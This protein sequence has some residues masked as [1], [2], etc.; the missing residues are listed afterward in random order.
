MKGFLKTWILEDSSENESFSQ[1][2]GKSGV[3]A[4][5]MVVCMVDII[6]KLLETTQGRAAV[7]SSQY[8]WSNAFDQQDPT[9]TIQKFIQLKIQAS[10]IPILIDFISKRSMK[11]KFNGKQAGPFDLVGGSP[12]GSFIGQLCYT[13]NSHDNT[14]AINIIDEDKYQYIDDLNLLELIFLADVLRQYDFF[15][16]VA[17]D[18]GIDQRFLP[19]SATQ[20]HNF[21]EGIAL[22]TQ[23]N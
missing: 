23:Q 22:W 13:T 6:L 2:G 21:N 9:K 16:H 3:G 4:Q 19:P 8:D 17:S 14:E 7:I 18:I 10:I 20:T 15:A 11:I 1:F 12:Q 5:H